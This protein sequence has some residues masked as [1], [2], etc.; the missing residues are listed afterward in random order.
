MDWSPF[1]LSLRVAGWSTLLSVV[2]G[3][4]VAYPLARRRFRG[5]ALAEGVVL[6][7]LV[8]P[9][10]VL[11]YALLV[12]L[13]RTGPIGWLWEVLWHRPLGLVFTWQGAVVA[14]T[15]AGIPL[16]ITQARVGLASVH[17]EIV[18]A[19]RIDGAGRLAVFLRI[20]V[21][22]AFPALIAGTALTFARALGD[23][24]ATLMVAGD[25]PGLTR[26]MS[27]AIY[28]AVIAGDTRVV[29]TFAIITCA[30]SLAASYLATGLARHHAS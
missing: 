18:D 5:R 19:A 27:L 6:L 30:L 4:A 13:S 10:T 26:T 3:L 21:P 8:M 2:L 28:D 25:T 12:L 11:G 17:P 1:W 15:V 14:A 22:L 9:P 24:G 20:L 23:F 7:P 29:E 16:F